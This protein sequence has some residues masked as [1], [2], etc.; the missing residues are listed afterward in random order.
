MLR[1]AAGREETH[2]SWEKM[3]VA[4]VGHMSRHLWGRTNASVYDKKNP[5]DQF[6]LLLANTSKNVFQHRLLFNRLV[7]VFSHTLH[8]DFKLN[9]SMTLVEFRSDSLRLEYF[10]LFWYECYTSGV[11]S[12]VSIYMNSVQCRCQSLVQRLN[13][14]AVLLYSPR[15]LPNESSLAFIVMF[16]GFVIQVRN[17]LFF[18]KFAQQGF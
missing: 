8:I 6:S 10:M 2:H 4:W 11:G 3:A 15:W 14:K 7:L 12:V 13:L 17:F 5:N 16:R 18:F 1:Q 9:Y